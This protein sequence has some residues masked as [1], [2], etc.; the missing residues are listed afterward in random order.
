ME[1]TAIKRINKRR[2]AEIQLLGKDAK[3][4]A[5]TFIVFIRQKS[6]SSLPNKNQ[7]QLFNLL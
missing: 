6:F 7:F 2:K 1:E 4:T 3:I 5:F